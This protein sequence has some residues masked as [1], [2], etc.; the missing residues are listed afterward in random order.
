MLKL[1]ADGTYQWARVLSSASEIDAMAPAPDGGVL[2]VGRSAES[3]VT[4]LTDERR[5]GLDVS[6]REARWR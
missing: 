2:V 4:R 1:A 5:I 6:D 3:F